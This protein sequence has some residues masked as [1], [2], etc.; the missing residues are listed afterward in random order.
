LKQRLRIQSFRDGLTQFLSPQIWKQVH[1]VANAKYTSPRWGL[2]PLFWVLLTSVWCTGDSHEERFATA[3]AAYVGC[4]Q[5]SRRPGESLAGF[6][7]AL[8]KTPMFV[9]RALA[10]GVRQQI[11]KLFVEPLRINGFVPIACD[12]SRLECPR[13]APLQRHLGEAGKPDSAP[14]IY[15]T[16]LVLL[17]LGIVWSWRWGKGTASEHDHLR[18]LLPTLPER[19]LLVADAAFLGYDLFC[20]I[21]QAPAS[22]LVRMS[23][24][25]YLYTLEERPLQRFREGIVYYWPG[26]VRRAGKPPLKVRLLRVRGNKADVWLLTNVLDRQ[27]L[28]RK[29]AATIYRWRWRNEGLFRTYK[30]LLKKVKLDSRT[31]ATV[32]REA[33]GSLLALQLMLALAA[34]QVRCAGEIRIIADSPRQMLLCIRG[35]V[36]ALLRSLGPRQF[37]KYQWML[38]IVRSD[39]RERTS[40]KERQR[41]PRRKP[42]T[43]PKPPN[44]RVMSEAAKGRMK[45]LLRAA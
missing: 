12:G 27:Q 14:M 15:L 32:H 3:R 45:Q 2:H 17:P 24:R 41:W 30:T 29:T 4:H 36:T 40:A 44:L 34:Q 28:S 43:P 6:L 19:A 25:A 37:A 5:R 21:L 16:T 22:F 23:S 18:H 38:Q 13:S 39:Q 11:G 9:L 20:A 10:H 31:V 26:D 8:A 1:Q 42:H 35:D 33:E 7:K